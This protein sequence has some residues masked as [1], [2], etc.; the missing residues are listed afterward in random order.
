MY[1][2]APKLVGYKLG[3]SFYCTTCLPNPPAEATEIY[4]SE[5]HGSCNVDT[6]CLDMCDTCAEPIDGLDCMVCES[7]YAEMK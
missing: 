6:G 2:V 4:D 5:T 1:F 7:D 3:G